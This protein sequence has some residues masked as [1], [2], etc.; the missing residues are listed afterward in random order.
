MENIQINDTVVYDD[1]GVEF[2]A[3]V[4]RIS[5]QVLTVRTISESGDFSEA[6]ELPVTDVVRIAAAA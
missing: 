4:D 2:T 1:G 3:I 6:H 5:G